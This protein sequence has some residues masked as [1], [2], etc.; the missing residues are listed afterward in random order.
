MKGIPVLMWR[1]YAEA[2]ALLGFQGLP[3]LRM[4]RAVVVCV[5]LSAVAR[6]ATINVGPSGS[7]AAYTSIQAAINVAQPGDTVLV[8]PGTYYENIDFKGKAITVTSSGGA[9]STIIDGGSAGPAASLKTGEPRTAVLSG[10]TLLNGTNSSNPGTVLVSDSTPTILNN[11]IRGGACGDMEVEFAAPL[12]Q[13]NNISGTLTTGYGCGVDG[14]AG[15]ALR[16]DYQSYTPGNQAL[17]PLIIGNTIENNIEGDGGGQ[18]AGQSRS[19]PLTRL[20]RTT[21]FA[22]M[23]PPSQPGQRLTPP[24]LRSRLSRRI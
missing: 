14:G 11:V 24:I 19:G 8:A 1:W 7:G 6:A 21:S 4:L 18:E 13:G 5:L 23:Y 9:A 2:S 16:G 20:L 15:I 17:V 3:M 22:I 10:F 12:I